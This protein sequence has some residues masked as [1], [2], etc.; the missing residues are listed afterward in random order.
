MLN[1]YLLLSIDFKHYMQYLY[2]KALLCFTIP[3]MQLGFNHLWQKVFFAFK[4][5]SSYIIW[6]YSICR[7]YRKMVEWL[8]KETKEMME[9][10]LAVVI[11]ETLVLH[12]I[13]TNIAYMV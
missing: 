11:R 5:D 2:L 1:A 8:N 3:G 6:M 13:I 4:Y 7:H 9:Q 10:F 12:H